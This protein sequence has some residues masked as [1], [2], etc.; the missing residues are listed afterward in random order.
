MRRSN[1]LY[2]PWYEGVLTWVIVGLGSWVGFALT[3]FL[4]K[5][6]YKAF[7]FGWNQI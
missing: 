3:G 6:V 4:S 5:I 2:A 1:N 7:M